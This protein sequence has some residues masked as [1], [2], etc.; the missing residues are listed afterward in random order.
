MSPAAAKHL[1]RAGCRF[2][3]SY[4]LFVMYAGSQRAQDT[5]NIRFI[6]HGGRVDVVK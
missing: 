2:V 1:A 3:G 5:L 6:T 4:G